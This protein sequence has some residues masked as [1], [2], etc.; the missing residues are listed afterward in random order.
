MKRMKYVVNYDFPGS[1]EQYCHRVGRTGRTE[2]DTGYSYSL[3]TRNMAPLVE[4]LITLLRNCN[5]LI[6]PNLEA[7]LSDY[8][9]GLV[10]LTPDEELNDIS[11]V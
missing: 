6:E 11:E 2:V 5:Q 10:D 9:N 4:D 8:Q 1:L 3:L 7:L